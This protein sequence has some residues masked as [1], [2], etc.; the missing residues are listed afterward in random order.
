MIFIEA[1]VQVNT[2]GNYLKSSSKSNMQR[3][4]PSQA[5]NFIVAGVLFIRDAP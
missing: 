4:I 2:P 1:F 3:A 5:V